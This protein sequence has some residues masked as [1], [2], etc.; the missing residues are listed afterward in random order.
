M[1]IVKIT[2]GLGNQLFQYAL[3][4]ALSL[5]LNCELVLDTSFYPLQ[6]LRKYELD[7]FHIKARLATTAEINKAGAGNHF[8]ARVIRKLGL[9]SLCYPNYIKELESI[10]YVDGVDNCKVGCYLDGYWQNP[11][12][13]EAVKK[14]LCED[15]APV[16]PISAPATKWLEKVKATES[17][18]LHVR[19][20]DYVQNAHTN[21]VHGTCSLDYYRNAIAHIQQQVYTPIFYIFSDEIQWCKDNLGFINNVNFVDDTCS[22][23][24]DLV[25][26]QNCKAN[27]IA[28]STFSWWGAWLNDS[29]DLQ[30]APVNWFT[31]SAR[32]SQGIYPQKW[33]KQ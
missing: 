12:Y 31:D 13:F 25:L 23:I 22:A 7:K 14:E 24:D 2:G 20:G 16:A 4:R 18:S 19:R 9:T 5:K 15:F 11:K 28:N 33:Y 8:I 17:V 6:T 29:Q 32:N 1:I 30:V 21:S 26:M 27:I 10:T 3:G